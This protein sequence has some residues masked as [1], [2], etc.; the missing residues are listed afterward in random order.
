MDTVFC[1]VTAVTMDDQM[2][3]LPGAFVGVRGGR[4]AYIG[5]HM[6]SEPVKEA[7]DGTGMVLMPGLIN[8]H[9]HLPMAPLRGWSEDK[10][11]QPWLESVWEIEA[12]MDERTVRNATL[13]GIMEALRLAPPPSARC[14]TTSVPSPRPWPRAASRP[15]SPGHHHVPGR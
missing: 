3:V 5:R 10:P 4:I 12:R 8:A 11:L 6:P 9:T 1:N 13:L 15:T 2:H 7:I 14:T